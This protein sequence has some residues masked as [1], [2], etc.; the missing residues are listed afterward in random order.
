[1]NSSVLERPIYHDAADTIAT[2]GFAEIDIDPSIL[3]EHM[4]IIRDGMR[5]MTNDASIH[6]IFAQQ[7]LKQDE[8]GWDQEAGLIYRDDAER[9]YFFH[10]Q[11]PPAIW[12]FPDDATQKRFTPFLESCK[13]LT[14]QARM[15][16][17]LVAFHFER[18]YG[19]SLS[20]NVTDANAVTRVLRYLPLVG[21]RAGNADAYAHMDRA[22]FTIHWWA[23]E[24]GLVLFDREGASHRI[25]EKAWDRVAI[26]PGKKF[27]GLTGGKYGMSG[28][29]GVRDS[30]TERTD[31]RIAIVTFVHATLTPKAVDC[32]KDNR[33]A[34]KVAEK[35]CAL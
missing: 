13:A 26:F 24:E 25:A 15:Y 30:R 27:Y 33:Q 1:M 21:N 19:I 17:Q 16:A 10:Y 4:P 22:F 32:I 3:A 35:C 2:R 5:T 23:S 11:S 18:E 7:I 31:D 12:P 6:E 20:R 8:M 29:H 9:K 14:T 28:I 34:F